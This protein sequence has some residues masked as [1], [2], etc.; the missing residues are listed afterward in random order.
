MTYTYPQ[1]ADT[2]PLT[3]LDNISAASIQEATSM[4]KQQSTRIHRS[5][6]E[7]IPPVKPPVP[8]KKPDI[9]PKHISHSKTPDITIPMA[10]AATL[11]SH[12][13]DVGL[14]ADQEDRIPPLPKKKY[15]ARNKIL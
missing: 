1:V 2:V 8:L 5:S 7:K 12:V 11:N 15:Q 13:A 9:K 3:D 14:T 10:S 6:M 4:G